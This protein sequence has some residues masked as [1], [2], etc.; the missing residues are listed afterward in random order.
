MDH[1]GERPVTTTNAYAALFSA[2]LAMTTPTHAAPP[3][4]WTVI[5]GGATA[6][7]SIYANAFFPQAIEIGVGDTVTWIF[8]GFHNVAL[9]GGGGAPAFSV[10]E[11]DKSYWNPLILFPA[12][13]KTYDGTG[14][15]NS[16]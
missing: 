16:D 12:G 7:T 6:D 5:V 9:L 15:H 4:H 8:E 10:Q 3:R 14:Y 11:G 2:L 13:D 1:K